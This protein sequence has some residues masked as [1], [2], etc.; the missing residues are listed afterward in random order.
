[1]SKLIRQ[2]AQSLDASRES[3]ASYELYG[4]KPQAAVYDKKV[5]DLEKLIQDPAFKLQDV[6]SNTFRSLILLWTEDRSS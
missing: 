1:M 6:V 2:F 3:N 4:A 5:E